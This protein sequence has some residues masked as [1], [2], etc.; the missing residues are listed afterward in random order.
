[1][2]ASTEGGIAFLEANNP[3]SFAGKGDWATHF[4][5]KQ[6]DVQ[7]AS[8]ELPEAALDRYML[9]KGLGYVA[10]DP[11]NF[12]RVYFIRLGYLWRPAPPPQLAGDISPKHTLWLALWWG[13]LTMFMC[14]AL[15]IHKPWRRAEHWPLLLVFIWGSLITPVFF[16]QMRY[17][18]PLELFIL[19][20]G[21]AGCVAAYNWW[22]RR[23]TSNIN[24]S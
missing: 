22:T 6:A 2:I 17:R 23:K 5:A 21:A 1:V 3:V 11:G 13:T 8:R 12:V 18:A 20:Y 4:S 7:K 9:R 14:V 15:T 10:A 16:S 24:S 19:L